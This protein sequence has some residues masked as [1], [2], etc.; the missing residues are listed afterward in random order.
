MATGRN[1]P[2]DAGNKIVKFKPRLSK[3]DSRARELV[4]C[5][6]KSRQLAATI[7]WPE[8]PPPRDWDGQS[9]DQLANLAFEGMPES[10][11][12]MASVS[13]RRNL[14]SNCKP[15]FMSLKSQLDRP[16]LRPGFRGASSQILPLI[17][18]KAPTRSLAL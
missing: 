8:I 6:N 7:A 18:R 10:F 17:A 3:R 11:A 15:V 1:T 2:A 9:D 4:E 16:S 5:F 14:E 13:P 12:A